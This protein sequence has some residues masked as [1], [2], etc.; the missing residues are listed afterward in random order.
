VVEAHPTAVIATDDAINPI[1]SFDDEVDPT[2]AGIT[3]V[4]Q[5]LP[6]ENPGIASIT[7]RFLKR[8][9]TELTRNG[10]RMSLEGFF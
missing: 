8:P 6:D 5:Q 2:G 10:H 3:R 4:L 7:S 9:S 1:S